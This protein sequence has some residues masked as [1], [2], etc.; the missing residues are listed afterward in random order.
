MP[1]LSVVIPLF[2][3]EISV[4]RA[5]ESVLAQTF[6]DFELI[7]IDDGS[8]DA[9]FHKANQFID[10]RLRII[11]QTN[12]GVAAAR[13]AGVFLSQADYVCFLDADD[14]YDIDFLDNI[15]HLIQQRP[16]AALF[17]CRY[18]IVDESGQLM[19]GSCSL[20]TD[21][22]GFVPNFFTTY[23]RS[24]SLICS[25]NF[26]AHKKFISAVGGF[27]VGILIGEDMYLWLRIALLGDFMFSSKI[28]ATI[29]RNAENR[30]IHLERH[31]ISYHASYFL[32]D[33]EWTKGLS[34]QMKRDVYQFIYHNA[35]INAAGA[36][37]NGHQEIALE[38]ALLLGKSNKKLA[39][40]IRSMC[41]LPKVVFTYGK[42]LR[43]LFTTRRNWINGPK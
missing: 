31:T 29:Y 6:R 17:A 39:Y 11:R 4:S 12:Q 8:T 20:P 1:F 9:S 19:L 37:M 15:Y 28:G 7:V 5:I 35:F 40:L 18:Q 14:E 38:Y 26:C 36:L 10:E 25:S 3:K 16:H 42:Y 13:N 41:L 32:S 30:T 23:R 27:P 2:N 24:R 21:F 33:E 43:N 34:E 22:T